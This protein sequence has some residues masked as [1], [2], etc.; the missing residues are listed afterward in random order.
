MN[1]HTRRSDPD[2]VLPLLFLRRYLFFLNQRRVSAS[3]SH[4]RGQRLAA[5]QSLAEVFQNRGDATLD[6]I[7]AQLQ[8]A[9][10]VNLFRLAP[11]LEAAL[12]EFPTPL[13]PRNLVACGGAPKGFFA[14][15]RRIL[16]VFGPAIGIGDEIICFPLPAALRHATGAEITVLSAYRDLWNGV[17]GVVNTRI[18]FTTRQLIEAMRG[19]VESPNDLIV[20]VDFENPGLTAAVCRE[21]AISR[22]AEISLGQRSASALDRRRG[23]LYRTALH[24]PYFANFYDCLDQLMNWF[25]LPVFRNRRPR[26]PSREFVVLVSPFTSK[27]NPLQRYWRRLLVSIL[28]LV[29]DRRIVFH[30]D[31]GPNEATEA[32]ALELARGAT[33]EAPLG[34]E[35][36][37][38]NGKGARLVSAMC[39]RH[40]EGTDLVLAADSFLAHATPVFGVPALIVARAG[41]ENWRAPETQNFYFRASDP[42]E[43]TAASMRVILQELYA[44]PSTDRSSSF[45]ESDECKV[46]IAASARVKRLLDEGADCFRDAWMDCYLAYCRV[47]ALLPDLPESFDALFAD[48]R[49]EDLF[50]PWPSANP[51]ESDLLAHLR[52]RWNDW[53]NS[54]LYKYLKG[55]DAR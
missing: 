42:V 27:Y 45:R 37:V 11:A 53:R 48:Q 25:G 26:K 39:S 16:L 15:A 19:T 44:N 20:F 38:A 49:Y 50:V 36:S 40:L 47:A 10:A 24:N 43:H 55:F 18:Y 6:R 9:T 32:F 51:G 33:A 52:N 13:F 31:S 23:C 12:D 29:R 41:V 28:P 2:L 54:N 35:Y 1:G 22:Y 5:L 30:I 4:F 34:V 21:P 14:D 7:S 46:L 8:A 3:N 17:D